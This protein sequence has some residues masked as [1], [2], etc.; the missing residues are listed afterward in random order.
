VT[1]QTT[2]S[3][4]TTAYGAGNSSGSGDITVAAPITWSSGNKLTLDAY[5]SVH[6]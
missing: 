2:A 6:V 5:R 1:V 3:S 4:A